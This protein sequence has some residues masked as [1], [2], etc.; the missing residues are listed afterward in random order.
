MSQTHDNNP[1]SDFKTGKFITRRVVRAWQLRAPSTYLAPGASNFTLM[2]EGTWVLED[3]RRRKHSSKSKDE[4]QRTAHRRWPVEAHLFPRKYRRLKKNRHQNK[5]IYLNIE[6]IQLESAESHKAR[7]D[8]ARIFWKGNYLRTAEDLQYVNHQEDLVA[9][10]RSDSDYWPIGRARVD[11][12]EYRRLSLRNLVL[13]L[14]LPARLHY[15]ALRLLGVALVVVAII[16]LAIGVY[17][18]VSG[19]IDD[20]ARNDTTVRIASIVLICLPAIGRGGLS[21][22]T[23]KSKT[24][25]PIAI[26]A[27]TAA[28]TVFFA[29]LAG[30][31]AG[32]DWPKSIHDALRQF[33]GGTYEQNLEGSIGLL[34]ESTALVSTLIVVMSFVVVAR[35]IFREAWDYTVARLRTYDL[36]IVGLG[37]STSQLMEDIRSNSTLGDTVNRIIIIE[38]DPANPRIPRVRQLGAQVIIRELD[39]DLLRQLATSPVIQGFRLG[40]KWKTEFILAFTSDEEFNLRVAELV[41]SLRSATRSQV[42]VINNDE[43]AGHVVVSV[44]VDDLWT[45]ERYWANPITHTDTRTQTYITNSLDTAAEEAYRTAEELHLAR[46]REHP[47]GPIVMVG[48]SLLG[49]A[50]LHKLRHEYLLRGLLEEMTSRYS[51]SAS[52]AWKWESVHWI[53]DERMQ[54]ASRDIQP[55]ETTWDPSVQ[56]GGSRMDVHRHEIAE[57]NATELIRSLRPSALIVLGRQAASEWHDFVPSTDES[58]WDPMVFVECDAKQRFEFDQGFGTSSR[59]TLRGPI[60]IVT[61]NGLVRPGSRLHGHAGILAEAVHKYFTYKDA[62][63]DE[64]QQWQSEFLDPLHRKSTFQLIDH[65]IGHLDKGGRAGGYI[66]QRVSRLSGGGEVYT[67]RLTPDEVEAAAI[68][69]HA[70][71]NRERQKEE[72]WNDLD[73]DERNKNRQ[74]IR[75]FERALFAIG[76]E[77]IRR[78]ETRACEEVG[79]ETSSSQEDAQSTESC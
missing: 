58:S 73:E 40:R 75:F 51:S 47:N 68:A 69:E 46:E 9:S 20:V 22:A 63:G 72:E 57:V 76:F 27:I 7:S 21:L 26:V 34:A 42:G 14:L 5:D 53:S 54:M 60:P 19:E 6:S 56:H 31:R 49:V 12:G 41:D 2:P 32:N 65:T 33:T 55:R 17:T 45:Q 77:L 61:D 79:P 44:R 35:T 48:Y 78:G 36:I 18:I 4:A 8:N 29:L 50:L 10:G 62:E 59:I 13:L 70:R 16:G 11:S 71:Y 43:G 1:R 23:P 3:V 38:R 39:E 74:S 52:A 28:T 37:N 25:S 66:L 15:L 24:P 67:E 64:R 30:H